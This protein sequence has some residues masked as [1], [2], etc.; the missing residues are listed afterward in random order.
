MRLCHFHNFGFKISENKV[1]FKFNFKPTLPSSSLT[2]TH[3]FTI[4]CNCEEIGGN[5]ILVK[6]NKYIKSFQTIHW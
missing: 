1:P 2:R 5:I 4:Y 6:I 3:I